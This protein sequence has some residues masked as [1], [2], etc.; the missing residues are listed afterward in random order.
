MTTNE[1]AKAATRAQLEYA[2]RDARAALREAVDGQQWAAVAKY[3]GQ[4]QTI[5][6]ALATDHDVILSVDDNGN[7]TAIPTGGRLT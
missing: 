5:R 7:V 1:T 3:A 6:E 4:L 2:Y